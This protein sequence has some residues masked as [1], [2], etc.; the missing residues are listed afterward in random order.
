MASHKLSP[1]WSDPPYRPINSSF[2]RDPA[3]Y[4]HIAPAGIIYGPY[5]YSPKQR[6]VPK[7]ETD[8][9]IAAE[10]TKFLN[11]VT[12]ENYEPILF[13]RNGVN[14]DTFVLLTSLCSRVP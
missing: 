11:E 13:R 14:L 6:T 2:G 4:K 7:A 3:I 1:V 12:F 8:P 10:G 5:D 9:L